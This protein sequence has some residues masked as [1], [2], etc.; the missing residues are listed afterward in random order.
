MGKSVLRRIMSFGLSAALAVGSTAFPQFGQ[1]AVKAADAGIQDFSLGDV[2]MLDEYSVNAFDKELDYLLAFDTNK[3]LAGFR[4]NAGLN[5]YGASRYGGW[6]NTNIAGHAVGHYMTAIAQAYQNPSIT[7]EQRA[8]LYKRMKTLIDGLV[9]CQKNSKGKQGF[10]WAAAHPNGTGVEVQF[11]NVEAGKS[12][13]INEAWVP[14]YTMHKI[15][16]GIVDIYNATGYAPA[17]DLGSNLGDW[18]YNRASGWNEQKR[19]TVLSI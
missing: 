10:I 13:I 8:E 1:T 14:W 12:N 6:E 3:L 7:D 15:I 4:Q 19:R 5:T 9:E 2:T 11:D 17:K 16:A 18:V